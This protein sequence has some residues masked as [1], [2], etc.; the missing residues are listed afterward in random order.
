MAGVRSFLRVM[1]PLWMLVLGLSG[2]SQ[3]APITGAEA[4]VA[5][6]RCAAP[7]FPEVQ[8]GLHLIGDRQPPVPYS[9]TPPTSGWHRSGVAGPGIATEP[10]SEPVQVGLLEAGLV[11]VTHG[12]LTDDEHAALAELAAR[13]PAAV[14]VT[15][16]TPLEPGAVAAAGWGV[17]QRCD[18]VDSAALETFV[19]FYAD[20]GEPHREASPTPQ[21]RE[22][23]AVPSPPAATAA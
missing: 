16:Y 6:D 2:C 23:D 11:V 7:E 5:T 17:L 14:A 18:G 22:A 10:L 15:P 21:V 12:R 8:A 1:T 3:V 9:S 13:F 20:P 4:P 19:R